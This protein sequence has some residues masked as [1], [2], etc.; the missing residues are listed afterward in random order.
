MSRLD[1]LM[2]VLKSCQGDECRYPWRQLHP[3]GQVG[4]LAEALVSGFDTFYENQPKVTFS[5][6]ELGYI[7]A[8]EG[9]QKFDVY[10]G[11]VREKR[12][13]DLLDFFKW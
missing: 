3:K 4:S 8:S 2:M 6:C 10:G 12:W 1:A 5:A 13:D 11:G 9:A 7:V